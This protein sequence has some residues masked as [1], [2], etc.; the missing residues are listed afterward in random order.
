MCSALSG[1]SPVRTR[2]IEIAIA[3]DQALDGEPHLLLGQPAHFEQTRLELFEL[4]LKVP[5]ALL[6]RGH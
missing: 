3:V 6:R 4:L 5:D 1:S 2:A